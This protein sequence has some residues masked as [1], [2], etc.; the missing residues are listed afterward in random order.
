[1]KAGDP[2]GAVHQ[3]A[4]GQGQHA[5]VA[6]LKLAKKHPFDRSVIVPFEPV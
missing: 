6:A 5:V 4:S 3:H 1:M 2:K